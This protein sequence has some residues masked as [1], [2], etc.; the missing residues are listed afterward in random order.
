MAKSYSLFTDSDIRAL[1]IEIVYATLF[2]GEIMPKVEITDWLQTTLSK[3]LKRPMAS[4]KAKSE[5]LIA[6]ILSDL[7]DR[8]PSFT[9]FSGYNFEV[10]K[11]LG[12]TG[13][14]DFIMSKKSNAVYIEAPIFAVVEAKNADID[15]GIPQCIAE[16]HASTIFNARQGNDLNVLYGTVTTGFDW[17]F[18][19]LHEKVAYVDT[20]VYT[21]KN[22][23]ELLGTL[24]FIV[25]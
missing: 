17:R 25:K 6:P 14:C 24:Q 10:D 1:G 19:R 20:E 18:I 12:L 23:T 5:H 22:L 9:Y 3:N 4:E 2:Q 7:Q 8:N 16:L 21:I 15:A 13:F 11:K